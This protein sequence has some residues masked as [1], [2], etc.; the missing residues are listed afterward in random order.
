[1]SFSFLHYPILLHNNSS[2]LWHQS[3][4]CLGL[5]YLVLLFSGSCFVSVSEMWYI[6]IEIVIPSLFWSHGVKDMFF[7]CQSSPVVVLSKGAKLPCFLLIG[8]IY[9]SKWHK[10]VGCV[11]STLF[12]WG[13]LILICW[14]V[15]VWRVPNCVIY[16]IL[17]KNTTNSLEGRCIF[18]EPELI[19][20]LESND[21]CLMRFQ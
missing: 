11:L 19:F 5:D 8:I 17:I 15:M 2:W 9:E 7:F 6:E 20:S 14:Y 10:L 1:M 16:T 12:N 13:G 18:P 3:F 4:R 21:M